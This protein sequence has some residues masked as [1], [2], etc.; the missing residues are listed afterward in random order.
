MGRYHC[1]RR[2]A[3]SSQVAQESAGQSPLRSSCAFRRRVRTM[4]TKAVRA[5]LLTVL[6]LAACTGNSRSSELSPSA[7]LRRG[8]RVLRQRSML[9]NS[10]SK[11]QQTQW[12]KTRWSSPLLQCR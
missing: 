4:L 3:R 8:T 5:A 9:S 1:R 6:A 7:R 2:A 11:A 10:A 12:S